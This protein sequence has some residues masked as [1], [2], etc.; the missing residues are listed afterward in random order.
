MGV[1]PHYKHFQHNGVNGPNIATVYSDRG[2]GVPGPEVS[3][4]SK[5]DPGA[6]F[7]MIHKVT[8]KFP[9]VKIVATTLREVHST[10]RHGWGSVAWIGGQS[11]VSLTCDLYV[12]AR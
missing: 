6:F 10:N 2:H 11:H 5:L 12:Y 1:K 8:E 9:D 3:S 4:K 7:G